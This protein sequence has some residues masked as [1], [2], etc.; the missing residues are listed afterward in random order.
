MDGVSVLIKK[1]SK[2]LMIQQPET[3]PLPCRWFAPSGAIK[4]GETIEQAARREIR[5]EVGLEIG[6]IRELAVLKSD[7]KTERTHFLLAGWK[8]GRVRPDPR[9]IKSCG[10]FTYEQILKLELMP[11]TRVF[12]E[13]HFRDF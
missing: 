2:Y 12:F 11:A 3:K 13:R 6:E 8:S 1:G 10:W 5:E 7:W 9:E 4:K